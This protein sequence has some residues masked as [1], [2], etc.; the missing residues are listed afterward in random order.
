MPTFLRSVGAEQ[1]RSVVADVV[2]QAADR[3][4]FVGAWVRL[5][6]HV[7]Q[8]LLGRVGVQPVVESAGIDYRWLPRMDMRARPGEASVVMMV[9][10][11][12]ASPPRP[13]RSQSA[14]NEAME[15]SAIARKRGDLPHP[16]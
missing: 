16:P 14:A 5:S 7:E 3:L 8:L 13:Q 10:D 4:D 11:S 12:T 15:P 2:H 1:S 9:K 6:H